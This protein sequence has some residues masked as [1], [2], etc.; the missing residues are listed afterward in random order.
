MAN[1]AGD[2]AGCFDETQALTLFAF[3]NVSIPFTQNLK[4]N[5]QTPERHPA[6][7]VVTRGPG[8]ACDSW[9]VQFYGSVIRD[10]ASGKFRMWYVAVSKTERL[11]SSLPRSVPWRVAYAESDDGIHWVKPDLGLVESGGSTSNN[12]V[13][14]DPHLGVLNLKVLYDPDDSNPAHR[15]RMG[16]HVWFPKNERRLGT[17]APYVS[18]DGLTW[19]LLTEA[20]P[21]DAELPEAATVIPP[22]HFEPVGGLYRWDGLFHL[23]GQNAITAPRPYHGRVSRTFVSSDF[24]SWTQASAI[25]FVRSSQH[26][27]LGPGKSRIGEQTHEGISVWN[28]GNVLVG[29]SGLWHGTP[30]WKDLTIDLGLVVS[31][32]GIHFREAMHE[33]VFLKRGPDGAWDQGGLLQ[34]QGFENVGHQTFIYY[35]AWDP[36]H[37]EDS[38]PRGGVGIATL[39]RDRFACLT[40]DTTTEGAGDYQMTQTVSSFLTTSLSL[41]NP[42]EKRLFVNVDGLSDQAALKIELLDHRLRPLPSYAGDNAAIVRTNGFQTQVLWDGGDRLV[43]LPDRVRIRVTFEGRRR[44]DIRFSALYVH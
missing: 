34:G 37:W 3:D 2:G 25:Q 36:R 31:N 35:G 5:M 10:A 9:A 17:F 1:D 42:A 15:Y 24:A 23:S 38:P 21:I 8:G 44:S 29:I 13:K 28:R 43:N 19:K 41:T 16:A 27:L 14:L 33:H 30:E 22:L 40:V 12:L 6:N 18:A 4:L 39:P 7:P 20:Q 32:D 26:K 11:D